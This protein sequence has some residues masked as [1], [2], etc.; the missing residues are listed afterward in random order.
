MVADIAPLQDWAVR[1]YSASKVPR[2]S[3]ADLAL[4]LQPG[5]TSFR[6]RCVPTWSGGGAYQR[7]DWIVAQVDYAD[8]WDI[9][10]FFRGGLNGEHAHDELGKEIAV[11]GKEWVKQCYRWADLEAYQFRFVFPY[12]L[13]PLPFAHVC[14][15]FDSSDCCWSTAGCTRTRLTPAVTTLTATRECLPFAPLSL[16]RTDREGL[17]PA[18]R[19]R[20]GTVP[21]ATSDQLDRQRADPIVDRILS[22]HIYAVPFI[23]DLCFVASQTPVYAA[24]DYYRGE[25]V[26]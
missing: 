8:M 18:R 23:H 11:A 12:L 6:C 15:R 19:S 13:R 1:A 3:E 10:A 26:A 14:T 2:R 22:P 16:R 5:S 20:S 7:T 21:S 4:C 9:M 24:S 25:C 17:R